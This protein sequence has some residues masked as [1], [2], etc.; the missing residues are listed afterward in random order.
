MKNKI[1]LVSF[2]LFACIALISC[3]TKN[4]NPDSTTSES[5]ALTPTITEKGV[6]PFVIGQS[7][8]NIPPKGGFYDTITLNR[9]YG[10]IM[11]DHYVEI[12]ENE[13]DDYYKTMGSD[14]YEPNDIIGTATVFSGNDTVMI[15]TYDESGEIYNIEVYSSKLK[16]DNGIHTGL[17]SEELFSQ[18]QAMFLTTDGFSGESWQVYHVPGVPQNISLCAYRNDTERCQWYYDIIGTPEPDRST[19]KCVKED[20]DGYSPIFSV[21][22]NFCK[23]NSIRKITITKDI[24]NMFLL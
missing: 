10:V 2:T 22:L 21:P 8:M 17:S 15:V 12:E 16:L 4:N 9:R 1:K 20:D 3:G 23:K 5:T 13:I 11:G 14:Y 19:F 24:N 6:V 7:I 18:Y